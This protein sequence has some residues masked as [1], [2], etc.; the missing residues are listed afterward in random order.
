MRKPCVMN[1]SPPEPF[2]RLGYRPVLDGYRAVAVLAVMAFHA[3]LP[4]AKGG[5]LGVDLFFVLSGFLI[6]SILLQEYDQKGSI[7]LKNF[8]GG[9]FSGSPPPSSR[10]WPCTA[11]SFANFAE[12]A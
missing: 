11:W 5:F 10:S 9:G 7:G 2:E 3:G 4:C 6:T 12:T 1:E 8:Y